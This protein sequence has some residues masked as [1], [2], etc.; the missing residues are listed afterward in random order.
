MYV[1]IF[2]KKYL[3]QAYIFKLLK[4]TQFYFTIRLWSINTSMTGFREVTK[5]ISTKIY[6]MPCNKNN[7]GSSE[8]R[9]FF[10]SDIF[11]RDI[12]LGHRIKFLVQSQFP[13]ARFFYQR[14]ALL[15][16]WPGWSVSLIGSRT[17]LSLNHLLNK[18]FLSLRPVRGMLK[19][20]QRTVRIYD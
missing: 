20:W 8:Q 10:A 9:Y 15:A 7:V 11:F 5:V 3:H 18:S 12:F 14:N 16:H 19:A 2:L 17:G 6:T 4:L 1:C 13:E